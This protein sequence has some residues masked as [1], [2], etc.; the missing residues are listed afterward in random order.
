MPHPSQIVNY[1][2]GKVI[3]VTGCT[4]FLGKLILERL[5][6]ICQ[7]R[8]V[9][10]LVRPKKGKSENERFEEMFDLPMLDPLKKSHPDFLQ[11]IKMIPGNLIMENM[12]VSDEHWRI[13]HEEVQIV[14]HCAATVRF[15][16][17]LRT[18]YQINV[19]ATRDLILNAKK[20]EK[21][22]SFVHVST[23]YSN[24][25]RY[26]IDEQVYEPT[27]NAEQLGVFL[28]E[29]QDDKL[30][31]RMTPPL[32][33]DWPNTYSFTKCIAEDM[34]NKIAQHLPVCI[35]RPSIIVSTYKEPIRGWVDNFY[36]PIGVAY[37]VALGLLRT[38]HCS[39]TNPADM[40][41]ADY[42]V[43]A[44]LATAWVTAQQKQQGKIENLEKEEKHR[45]EVYNYTSNEYS[46]NWQIY[47]DKCKETGLKIVSIRSLWRV[48]FTLN[49]SAWMHNLYWFFLHTIPAHIV[50]FCC[51]IIGK[52][53]I[54]VDGYE[55]I[56][57]FTN[58]I[59]YFTIRKWSLP[60]NKINKL[61]QKFNEKDKEL[62]E[63]RMSTF[64][65]DEFMENFL[66]GGRLYLAKE[67]MD[68]LPEARRRY[69]R[70]VIAHWT[71]V[72]LVITG[73]L[74]FC[75]FLLKFLIKT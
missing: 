17:H 19:R 62:F 21:L 2:T 73:M 8:L 20:M 42:V 71:I 35:I 12:G 69:R 10:I 53:P 65:W 4:G 3:L 11:R 15:D 36:G 37:A 72:S 7:V 48:T 46:I 61:W 34:V 64:D 24:C 47:M 29:F 25:P 31:E 43:N 60:H 70:L 22:E 16:Q 33:G 18:A 54:M 40:V 58:V 51:R 26:E 39:K 63:I 28:E 41:P 55:K 57:R 68:T 74:Y 56:R 75:Y 38:L 14:I 23:A 59:N 50:D 45:V 52:E 66:K 67:S 49:E 5:L 32:L 6:R 9:Y 1:F 30:V 27:I 13:L 44:T